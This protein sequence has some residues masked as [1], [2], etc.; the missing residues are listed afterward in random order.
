MVVTQLQEQ[1]INAI[2]SYQLEKAKSVAS[3]QE[4]PFNS[5]SQIS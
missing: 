4:I 2:E 3:I 5:L 1:I